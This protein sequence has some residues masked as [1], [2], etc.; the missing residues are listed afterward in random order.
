DIEKQT[1]LNFFQIVID[2]FFFISILNGLFSS[3]MTDQAISNYSLLRGNTIF[4]DLLA[5]KIQQ[6][7][8]I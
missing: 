5:K 3:N 7:L 6:F 2:H 8:P 1:P 4:L